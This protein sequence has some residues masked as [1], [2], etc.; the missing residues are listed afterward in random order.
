MFI[1]YLIGFNVVFLRKLFENEIF[2]F[3]LAFG[4]DSNRGEPPWLV[5][6]QATHLYIYA[7][8]KINIS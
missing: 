3:H 2:V 4:G 8:K 5:S 1:T 7:V 6:Y